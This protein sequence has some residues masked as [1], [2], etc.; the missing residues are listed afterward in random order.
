MLQSPHM[1]LQL[2]ARNPSMVISFMCAVFVWP[3]TNHPT[4]HTRVFL[5]RTVRPVKVNTGA[6]RARQRLVT[7]MVA[8]KEQLAAL[9]ADLTAL[10]K[11]KHCNPIM[12][13]LAWHDSGSYNKVR[14]LNS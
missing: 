2:G 7:T 12:I 9:K 10:I 3:N 11:E 13:R 14:D 5:P 6:T 8:N 1:Q 4:M